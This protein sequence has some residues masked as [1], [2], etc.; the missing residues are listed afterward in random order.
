MHA[1]DQRRPDQVGIERH[2]DVMVD[3]VALHLEMAGVAGDRARRLDQLLRRRADEIGAA[4]RFANGLRPL[5][6]E[7][8]PT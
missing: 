3:L 5:G 6:V 7:T 2:L 4:D 8:T 1:A